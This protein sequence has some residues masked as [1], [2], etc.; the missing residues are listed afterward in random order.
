MADA[1]TYWIIVGST[2]NFAKT[3]DL[4]FTKHG[5]KSRH[6]KKAEK[7]KPGDKFIFYLTGVKRFAGIATVESEYF[8]EHTRI[9]SAGDP[10]KADE[11]YPFRVQ[12]SADIILP[13]G[14]EIEAEPLA[15]QMHYATKWPAANWT[16]AFQGNVHVIGEADY[17]LIRAALD[18]QAAALAGRGG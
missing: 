1:P 10:K 11:D 14:Q 13:E 2:D 17:A 16:L 9:W 6:R 3:R 4:G 15:R 7:M 18:A 5:I 8:E 12:I